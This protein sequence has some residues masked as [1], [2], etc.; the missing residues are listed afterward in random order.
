MMILLIDDSEPERALTRKILE[1]EGYEVREAADGGEGLALFLEL[2]PALVLC[3][4][5]MPTSGFDTVREIRRRAPDA[6]IVAI[7]G[8]MFG[9][10]DHEMLMANLGLAG[11]IEKPFR[12]AQ[13]VDIVRRALGVTR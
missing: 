2:R 10:A 12:P 13:L 4:L 11:V 7:S 6:R 9:A 5:M 1:A 8:T 3:D